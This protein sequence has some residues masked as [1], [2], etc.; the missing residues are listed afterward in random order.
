[1]LYTKIIP[2]LAL[3]ALLVLALP[4]SA[5]ELNPR[6]PFGR[7]TAEDEGIQKASAMAADGTLYVAWLGKPSAT[8]VPVRFASVIDRQA[9]APIT[10]TDLDAQRPNQ[11]RPLALAVAGASVYLAY[12]PDDRHVCY[13]QRTGSRWA[14]PSC[15]QSPTLLPPSAE[16]D[17]AVLADG[18]VALAWQHERLGVALQR[19]GGAWQ[20]LADP[21]GDTPR[22]RTQ[23]RLA[24]VGND[25]A[26][27]WIQRREDG[28]GSSVRTELLG[29][30][31]SNGGW[32]QPVA[33]SGFDPQ[34]I[35]W[36]VQDPT[37]VVERGALHVAYVLFAPESESR[38]VNQIMYRSGVLAQLSQPERLGRGAARPWLAVRAG[39]VELAWSAE[40]GPI[41]GGLRVTNQEIL[42]SRRGAGWSEPLNISYSAD[43]SQQPELFIAPGGQSVV[44][45]R[46]W[47]DGPAIF[48]KRYTSSQTWSAPTPVDLDALRSYVARADQPV[49]T[50][51]AARSWLWGPSQWAVERE[52]YMEAGGA[53]RSVF[54]YD[55]ARIE[56]TDPNRASADPAYFTNG[57][58][59]TEM[60]S[61]RVQYGDQIFI[62]SQ[63]ATLPVVGDSTSALT[64][65][66]G[67]FR[68]LVFIPEIG[69]RNQA[70][71]RTGQRV[72]QCVNRS[73]AVTTCTPA[74]VTTYAHFVAE[75]GHNI[76][77]PFWTF[78]NQSGPVE[79]N[80]AIRSG[81]VF[82]W[83]PTMGYP[84]AEPYWTRAVVGGVERDVLVQLFQRRVLSYTPGNPRGFEVEMGNVGQHYYAWRYGK[85][86][87]VK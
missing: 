21:A 47:F 29:R 5:A 13:Q 59:V 82:A 73:G 77:A 32:G 16:I 51:A 6:A 10:V 40:V 81:Q 39:V 38:A 7:I 42:W 61:G 55:K 78:L 50:G 43:V 45:W 57:L 46:N 8:G 34:Q 30:T 33:I 28:P 58:L 37:V 41:I 2:L 75:T 60:A 4:V 79:E 85:T 17:L 65:T 87:W 67:S 64:P 76:A 11:P 52:P 80:G 36:Q 44:V 48:V 72:N 86:P 25:L 9:V 53:A 27:L 68:S 31:W 23:P 24:A 14:A 20:V 71:N 69:Q 63:P 62:G 26:V 66:Y 70:L 56:A 18:T 12:N 35:Q 3:A 84:I 22:E 19:P 74:T 49:A 83:L 1:M 54:Y 15:V